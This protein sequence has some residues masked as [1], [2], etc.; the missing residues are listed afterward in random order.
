MWLLI[1]DVIRRR[2]LRILGTVALLGAWWLGHLGE[3]QDTA[4]TQ[5]LRNLSMCAAFWLG[6][7][8][9]LSELGK[10]VLR[11]MPV[12]RRDIWMAGVM[13]A[14]VIA[15]TCTT[16]AKLVALSV[17]AL[18]GGHVSLG[19]SS[20]A[21]SSVCD[22]LYGGA[23]AGLVTFYPL[24]RLRSRW[25]LVSIAGEFLLAIAWLGGPLWPLLVPVPAHWPDLVGPRGFGLAPLWAATAAALTATAF[26][27]TPSIVSRRRRGAFAGATAR[28][29]GARPSATPMPDRVVRKRVRDDLDGIALLAWN[30]A[31]WAFLGLVFFLVLDALWLHTTVA[32]SLHGWPRFVAPRGTAF[33]LVIA[34]GLTAAV[35]RSTTG[36]TSMRVIRTLPLGVWQLTAL[37]IG[38]P[39]LQLFIWYAAL[40]AIHFAIP[41]YLPVALHPGRVLGVVAVVAVAT[42]ISYAPSG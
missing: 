30:T 6:P 37:L 12:S 26:V 14:T 9:A 39:L 10:P 27:R 7:L 2:W 28:P 41:S 13:L 25:G 3:V 32:L 15:T 8:M 35:T 17:A 1:L 36:L 40:A 24:S 42:M 20:I 31:T 11:L 34:F 19:L 22:F 4:G 23:F 21:L 29:V 18:S 33:V 16:I 5:P 38:V